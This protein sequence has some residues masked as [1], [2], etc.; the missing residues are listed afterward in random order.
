M[1][2]SVSVASL[3]D[4]RIYAEAVDAFENV[5]HLAEAVTVK[6]KCKVSLGL[7]AVEQTGL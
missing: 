7:Q 4:I 6:I 3:G 1:V 2:F 5:L